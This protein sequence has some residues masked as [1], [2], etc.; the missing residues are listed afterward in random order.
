MQ[1]FFLPWCGVVLSPLG[2]GRCG[3][4]TKL[5]LQGCSLVV[6]SKVGS[7]AILDCS[8][9]NSMPNIHHLQPTLLIRLINS[10]D[11]FVTTKNA[12]FADLM[13]AESGRERYAQSR[14]TEQHS[15]E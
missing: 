15:S 13:L 9:V 3:E 5:F 8:S 4:V 11:Y 12:P 7:R 1:P 6:W 10:L 14:I 2:D